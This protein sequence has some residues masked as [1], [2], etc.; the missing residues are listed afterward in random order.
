MNT[1]N[2]NR[3]IN[4]K[5]KRAKKCKAIRKRVKTYQVLGGESFYTSALLNNIQI[6]NLINLAL[7]IIVILY[8]LI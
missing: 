4:L 5:N 6:Y 1:P 7:F 2:E 8:S 3:S